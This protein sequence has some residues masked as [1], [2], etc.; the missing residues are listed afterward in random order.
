VT[1]N[2]SNLPAP[3]IDRFDLKILPMAF[4][5]E[6]VQYH[7]YLQGQEIDLGSF[8][9]MMREGK[10]FVTSLISAG[11][12]KTLLDPLIEATDEDILYLGLSSG[13]SG[14]FDVVNSYFSEQQK[15]HPDRRFIALDGLAASLGEGLLILQA[16]RLREE[17]KTLDEVCAW[18]EENILH[19]GH[20]FT[21]DD[22]M[23][24]FRG[25]RLSRTS[26]LAGTLLDIKPILHIDNEG[27]LTPVAKVRNRRKSLVALV[28]RLEETAIRPLNTSLLA[29]SHG[30]CEKDA[31]FVADLICER[32]AEVTR[33]DIIINVIDPVVGAHSGPGTVALFFQA[34]ER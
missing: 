26:A 18:L 28:D 23:F 22:L 29:I 31:L 1:D 34:Q 25:G 30:D 24:L 7:S 4:S 20:C 15:Q 19:I 12:C 10:E 9:H 27:K 5:C 16:A 11:D 2:G 8:Y 21:V 13:V 33:D 14:S 6:G 32:F 17:G 3:I